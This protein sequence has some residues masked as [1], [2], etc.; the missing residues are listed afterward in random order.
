MLNIITIPVPSLRERSEE[1]SPRKLKEAKLQKFMEELIP[2]MYADEGIGIASPQVG[3]NLRICIIGK[4]A[5]PKRH[6]HAGKDLILVNPEWQKIGKKM[7]KESEG[8]LSVPGA[9][10]PVK[11]YKDIL[12]FGQNE[13]GEK[14]E[15]EAHGFLARVVQHEVDHL[16]G[17]LYIDRAEELFESE[18]SKKI[19]FETILDNVKSIS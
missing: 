8:C 17:I 14:L 3:V 10:G 18:H 19:L 2:T 7:I 5:F 6:E 11:R 13:Q 1:V 4:A 15:F 9:Y 12:V 16:N